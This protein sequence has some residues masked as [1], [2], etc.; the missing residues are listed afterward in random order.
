MTRSYA[1]RFV[2]SGISVVQSR[3]YVNFGM[4]SLVSG[5]V[6][7]VVSTKEKIARYSV[8]NSML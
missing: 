3:R 1:L 6:G 8:A 2:T 4:V 7:L 5:V